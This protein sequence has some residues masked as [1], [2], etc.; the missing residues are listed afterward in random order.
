MK[1]WKYFL[2]IKVYNSNKHKNIKEI[3]IVAGT[4]ALITTLG[5]VEVATVASIVRE[6]EKDIK[7]NIN[8]W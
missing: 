7:K 4:K 2:L 5:E 6:K 1:S 3:R 8:N